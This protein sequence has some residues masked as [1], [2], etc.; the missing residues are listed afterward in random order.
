MTEFYAIVTVCFALAVIS[1]KLAGRALNPVCLVVLA[2]FIT[3]W[4]FYLSNLTDDAYYLVEAIR[5]SALVIACYII[6]INRY[7]L[8]FLFYAVILSLQL[9]LTIIEIALDVPFSNTA[10]FILSCFEIALFIHGIGRVERAKDDD[11]NT[12]KHCDDN[13]WDLSSRRDKHGKEA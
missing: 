4:P 12:T 1:V 5:I 11:S 13:G 8:P 2:S 10:Y 9:T 3:F 7:V 6:S